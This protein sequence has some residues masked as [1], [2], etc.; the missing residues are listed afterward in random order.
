MAAIDRATDGR[1][2][3]CAIAAGTLPREV[4]YQDHEL[5][6][7]RNALRWVPTMLLVAPIEHMSQTEFWSS[8]LFARA[9]SLATEIGE[10]DAPTGFRIVSNFGSDAM[11][12]QPHGHLHVLGGAHLGLYLDFPEKSDF[13]MKFYGQESHDP[14][15]F[16]G[17]LP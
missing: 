6:V 14:E 8:S 4:R 11:Q 2:A 1:C 12:S 16:R 5:I 13:W 17:K 3:F 7:F 15:T 10:S 9:A